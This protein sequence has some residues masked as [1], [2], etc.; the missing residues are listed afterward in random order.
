MQINIH[1][2]TCQHVLEIST[3]MS[4]NS[5]CQH[6]KIAC[7]HA[8]KHVNIKHC[9]STCKKCMLTCICFPTCIR[10]DLYIIYCETVSMSRRIHISYL[11]ARR[12]VYVCQQFS[13]WCVLAEFAS[14]MYEFEVYA[15]DVCGGMLDVM[16]IYIY[17]ECA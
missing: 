1:A 16:N 13:S 15:R 10:G 14:W 4:I 12:K 11:N 6:T 2:N 8:E 5:I 3:S 17:R 9:M 7:Q